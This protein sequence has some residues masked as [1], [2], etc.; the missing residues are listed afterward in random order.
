M[1]VVVLVALTAAFQGRGARAQLVA[2]ARFDP[3][4]RDFTGLFAAAVAA[5]GDE[6]MTNVEYVANDFPK[7]VF[8]QE[9]IPQFDDAFEAPDPLAL[10][11]VAW[12]LTDGVARHPVLVVE[13]MELGYD[14]YVRYVLPHSLR[15]LEAFRERKWPVVWTNWM[16]R[17]DDGYYG[18][19][20]R[21][22]GP[23]G[24]AN[25]ENPMYIYGEDATGTVGSLKAKSPPELRRTIQSLHLSKFADLDNDGQPILYPLLKSW[26]VDT[27]V[28]IGAWTEDCVLATVYD[29]ADKF[30]FDV[31]LV[32]DAVAT[33]SDLNGAA[34]RVAKGTLVNLLNTTE[35]L[36]DLDAFHK[37]PRYDDAE[38][39]A[40]SPPPI[41]AGKASTMPPKDAYLMRPADDKRPGGGRKHLLHSYL[42]SAEAASSSSSSDGRVSVNAALALAALSAALS[43]VVVSAVFHVRGSTAKDYTP[44]A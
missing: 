34:I 35:L 27:L 13:D 1:R 43:A 3:G 40:P 39:I 37:P 41:G 42:S 6:A 30:G 31:V 12:N 28:I 44:V 5:H 38:L 32:S 22:Y 8:D 25:E 24:I 29:A 20:D 11:D 2:S 14:E 17:A 19:V 10:Y 23:R 4:T 9:G 26:G 36:H 33:A 21:Y 7:T 18:S 15:I 16:R